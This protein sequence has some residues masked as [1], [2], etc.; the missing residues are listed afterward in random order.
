MYCHTDRFTTTEKALMNVIT[1]EQASPSV[2]SFILSAEDRGL[3]SVANYVKGDEKPF[4]KLKYPQWMLLQENQD[5]K[6]MAVDKAH[7]CQSL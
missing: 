5:Q 7:F 3:E 2:A 4:Q 1:N 6:R